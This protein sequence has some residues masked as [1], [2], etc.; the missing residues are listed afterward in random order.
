MKPANTPTTPVRVMH[1]GKYFPPDPGG[2]ETYLKDLM[3]CT[4][5]MGTTSAALVHQSKLGLR[6]KEEHYQSQG[7][8][9]GVTRVATWLRA[10]FTPLSPSFPWV[11]NR[12][13]KE[14]RPQILHM[15][16]P[17]PSAFWAL[18][19]PGARRLPWV[20]HWQSDV[21]TPK[22]SWI[23]R[24]CYLA[25]KPFESALLKRA[26]RIIATSSQYL[27][28]SRALA[29][30]RG[31]CCV[32]S[33]GIADRFGKQVAEKT[34]TIPNGPLRV[35]AIGRLAHYKGFDVLLRAIAH[36]DHTELDIV[37]SGEQFG[38][39]T[40]LSESLGLAHRVRFHGAVSD[41]D[42]D[43]LILNSDCLCLPSI[44]RT[45]SF[46]IAL[47]E[48]M[49][50]GKACVISE[51][52]GSGM[53]AVVEADKTGLVVPP[54]DYVAL[55]EAFDWLTQHRH[56][57]VQMGCLGRTKFETELTIDVSAARVIGIYDKVQRAPQC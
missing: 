7:I 43:N 11:L 28:S 32:I 24:F 33:L 48:A 57:L 47:L 12:L 51:V 53:T 54:G 30:F 46:G 6:S 13:I 52:P 16:L 39:L 45:E 4:Q 56:Q 22:S 19:I 49:S 1:I 36:T 42:R 41:A 31:K 25:Y 3:V 38:K 55:A 21:L 18:L 5:K 29:P 10:L 17:N 9:L 14:Q 8:T 44:D 20:V 34:E 35:L 2:M 37:G 27:A 26:D 50:A 40:S 23:I 15:H